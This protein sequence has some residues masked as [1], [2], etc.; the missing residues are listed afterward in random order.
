[1][2]QKYGVDIRIIERGSIVT[3]VF[4]HNR[5]ELAIDTL[6]LTAF[7]E[8][9]HKKTGPRD[10][11]RQEE[12]QA[13]EQEISDPERYKGV[14]YQLA[15]DC[16]QAG[17][18]ARHLELPRVE[19]EGRFQRAE[20]IAEKVG[21]QRQM[22]RI[23]Y[24]RA[25]T[26]FWWHDD[27]DALNTTYDQVEKLA[28]G[29]QQADDLEL[30]SNLWRLVSMGMM[31]SKL[32]PLQANFEA[33]TRTLETELDRLSADETRPNNALRA[34]TFRTLMN[35]IPAVLTDPR[36]R[37]EVLDEL[38]EI[39]VASEGLSAYPLEPATSI[40]SELGEHITD[41]T[42]YDSLFE[43]LVK[44]NERRTSEAEVGRML[45][46]RGMQ[47]LRS[48]KKYEAISLR[49][50]AQQKLAMH[51][52]RA[53]WIIA[54]LGAGSA[55]ESAGLLWAARSSFITAA[56]L[57][58]S[59][60]VERGRIIPHTLVCTRR[61]AWLEIRLGR[62][63]CV[64]A[65]VEMMSMLAL[66]LMLEGD[67]LQEYLDERMLQDRVIG[68]LLLKTDFSQLKWLDFLPEILKKLRLDASRMALLYALG[69]QDYLRSEKVIPEG[70][71]DNDVLDFFLNGSTNPPHAS[72]LKNLNLW[73]GRKSH[74]IRSYLDV[75][76]R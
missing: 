56:N 46:Q 25:W 28:V 41:S 71:D 13:L 4:E 68:L 45:L 58:F 27:F 57:A 38:K 16:L 9:Q 31:I 2:K 34:R 69:H 12:L 18:L 10:V 70:E 64:L 62:V 47:K 73:R 50:R 59:E 42:S 54:Q 51:E 7:D 11:V 76:L 5:I 14:E 55:Y 66:Q 1:L 49:G 21:N 15:E 53:E 20:R 72:F 40:V 44:L 17:L 33:R 24:S 32:D 75:S 23:A 3:R 48:N 52:H 6:G 26:A 8:K 37:D 74:L 60:L 61:L 19:I 22:L 29:T 43:H 36:K 39:L 63:P 35:L 67:Q 30:L 65:W